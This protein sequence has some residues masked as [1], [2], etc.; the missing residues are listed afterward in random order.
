MA[1]DKRDGDDL[2]EDLD[3]FFAP[4]KDVDWDEP[5]SGGPE[6][7]PS[8]EHVSV[9]SDAVSEVSEPESA[10]PEDD[11]DDWYDTGVIDPID[12]V[13]DDLIEDAT[14]AV[15]EG[16]DAADDDDPTID[17]LLADVPSAE[18]DTDTAEWTFEGEASEES[19][20]D[21]G[22]VI[23]ATPSFLDEPDEAPSPEDL[24]A[25]A[26]HFA[27]S[28][29]SGAAQGSDD[30]PVAV[31]IG[32]ELV[33][34]DAGADEVERD[35]LSDLDEQSVSTVVVGEG[36]GGPSWQ[37]PGTME[38]GADTRGA[39]SGERDVPAAFLTGLVLLGVALGALAIGK[40][41]FGLLAWIVVML[42]QVEM[43]GVTTRSGRQPATAIGLL[44][45]TLMML[46]A[47][48]YGESAV[49]AMLALGIMATF[50][51]FMAG[52]AAHRKDTN[53]NIGLTSMNVAWIPL[54]ASY[55]LVILRQP[56]GTSL[57]VAMIGLTFV[58]DTAAFLGGSV[59]GGQFFQRPLAPSVS[60]KKSIEGLV[61][62]ALAT[63][64]VSV[65]FVTS[66]V[67][68]FEGLRVEALLLALVVSAA[69]T[70]GDLAESL[71]KR[72]LGIKDMGSVLP[73]HGGVLDR[74]DSLLFVAPA[75]FLFLRVV[76]A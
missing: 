58:F 43:F 35:I 44:T 47:Y 23:S 5:T 50:L 16:A 7:A 11:D 65:A 55:L 41:A 26:E 25:A 54:L 51:W 12:G 63:M 57:V 19:A 49:L 8:E 33:D 22:D 72:D 39:G 75:V 30:E 31:V 34:D 37:D 59:M 70:I 73:G 52:P 21:S 45:G 56:D 2:F 29:R 4:I 42:A 68:P 62:A 36:L 3:K 15:D 53:V 17:E 28:I 6:D 18:V 38:V 20:A 1:G 24:E 27:G 76:F 32:A 48:R 71:V 10:T 69:A 67:A 74:I 60:P 9:R 61:I 64:I 46:G 66:F 40:P 13:G 14:V